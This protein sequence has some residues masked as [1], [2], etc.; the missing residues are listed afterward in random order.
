[1]RRRS[2]LEACLAL[3]AVLAVGGAAA[4]AKPRWIAAPPPPDMIG[5]R[6]SWWIDQASISK[7]GDVRFFVYLRGSAPGRPPA[8][9]LAPGQGLTA[10]QCRTGESFVT[11]LC[12]VPCRSDRP[13]PD[14][15]IPGRRF[16]KKE[17]VYRAVCG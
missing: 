5:E 15:W 9:P 7:R 14:G 6:G 1:M 3:T 17:P 13:F 8:A 12:S 16:T 4:P 2:T 11:G 10:I